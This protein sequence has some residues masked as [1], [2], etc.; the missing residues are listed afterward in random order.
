MVLALIEGAEPLGHTREQILAGV[1]VTH[2]EL[3]AQG[4][5][6]SWNTLCTCI[7]NVESAGATSADLERMGATIARSPHLL[8]ERFVGF[9]VRPEQLLYLGLRWVGPSQFPVLDHE[10]DYRGRQMTLRLALP[11]GF[12]GSEG[13][14]HICRGTV[15]SIPTTVG[16]PAAIITGPITSHSAVFEIE[17]RPYRT[18][19]GRLRRVAQVLRSA[20]GVVRTLEQQERELR[21][22]LEA[23]VQFQH[24]FRQMID[25][26][27]DAVLIYHGGAV[28]YANPELPRLLGFEHAA[29]L[30]GKRWSEL[31]HAED[32][33]RAP[34]EPDA[35]VDLRFVRRDGSLATLELSAGESIHY[36]NQPA[37]IVVARDI[38]DQKALRERMA[39]A[40]RMTSLGTMAAGLAHEINNPLTLVMTNL[41]LMHA[42]GVDMTPTER[43]ARL[44]SAMEGAQRIKQ[45][46]QD[47][48]IF[49]QPDQERAAPIDLADVVRSTLTLMGGQIEAKS[50]LTV[51][52]EAGLPAVMA[53]RGRA[54]QVVLN[55][56]INALHA[57]P[58]RPVSQ[59]S[60]DVR[61]FGEGEAVV[62]SIADNGS[63]IP[64]EVR[65]RV[66]EP[67]YSTKRISEGTGLGLA[68]AREIID[69]YDGAITFSTEL[70]VGTTF[71]IALPAA[72]DD[73]V[74]SPA[75]PKARAVAPDPCSGRVLAIDDDPPVLDAVKAI[76]EATGRCV[77]AVS[78]GCEAIQLLEHDQGFDA[79]VCDLMMSHGSGAEV[80]AFLK[81]AH[82]ELAER[83]V[84]MT[85]GIF[86]PEARS[87][88]AC[89]T[90]ECVQKPFTVEELSRAVSRVLPAP[91]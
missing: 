85:G 24:Q 79:I 47:L 25:A 17:V 88:L 46:S 11:E 21:R 91:S 27:P 60:I 3:V 55:V 69:C 83:I 2:S 41:E 36:A 32:V 70:A 61:L 76:L 6:V 12:P 74:A 65:G 50:R 38:S 10:L 54:G 13:Y 56:L 66:F 52:L 48:R 64:P 35:R 39:V 37:C 77:V 86:Q 23:S 58:D 40:D 51:E 89:V 71:R 57:L 44:L 34:A 33:A 1:P 53:N 18:T 45:V 16:H 63:G 80:H 49:S 67:F 59:N 30:I 73:A 26:L 90:N 9:I 87:F 43:N 4:S 19:I 75:S 29:Q 14:F 31:L 84:F 82:P 42:R 72:A 68:I 22:S 20:P 28:V 62:I 5:R 7:R 8:I 15:A 81:A 78:S